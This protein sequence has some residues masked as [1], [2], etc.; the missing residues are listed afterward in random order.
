MEENGEGSRVIT[1]DL[2]EGTSISIAQGLMHFAQNMGCERAQFLANFPHR[3]AH[4]PC[5]V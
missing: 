5:A 1:E 4:S 2:K 3:G